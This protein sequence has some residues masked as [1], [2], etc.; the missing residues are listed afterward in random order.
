[1]LDTLYSIYTDLDMQD[2]IKR[3][4]KRYKELGIEN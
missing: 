3:L 4:D 2:Q 1:V